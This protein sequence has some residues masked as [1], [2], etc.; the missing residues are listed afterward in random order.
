MESL[1]REWSGD[2]DLGDGQLEQ[3]H[4]TYMQLISFI[5]GIWFRKTK[6]LASCYPGLEG[7]VENTNK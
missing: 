3:L 1:H 4:Q 7:R 6:A 5:Q 2:V